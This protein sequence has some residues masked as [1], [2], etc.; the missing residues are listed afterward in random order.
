M[1]YLASDHAGYELK[2]KIKLHLLKTNV[3]CE[4]VGVFSK[5]DESGCVK[6]A[7]ALAAKVLEQN[8]NKGILI[9]G[10]GIC[11][12]IAVNRF[13]G[14]R[15]ALCFNKQMAILSKQ[16]NNANVLIMGARVIKHGSAK[17]MVELFLS[18]PFLGGKY[19]ERMNQIDN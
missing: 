16:H 1:L 10:T 7:K 19:Q 17:K 9:C 6:F 15:G 18:T 4:D 12:S 5:A 3:A 8:E 11:M 13:R 14:I 2:E